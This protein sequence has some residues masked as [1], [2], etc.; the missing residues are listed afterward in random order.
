MKSLTV[1]LDASVI[2]AGLASP[3]GGSGKLFAAAI[4]K[5]LTLITTPL[6]IN[7]V[8]RHLGKLKLKEKQLTDC[9]NQNLISLKS[10]PKTELI[11]HFNKFTQDPNDA[12]VL[13]GAISTNCRILLTL[14]KK[15]LLTTKAKKA[16]KPIQILSPKEFWQQLIP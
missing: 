5:K 10:N 15:H 9:L 3:N 2:L 6:I 8:K 12:H 14:D 4:K 16:L 7:E 1:F 11:Q 13:A